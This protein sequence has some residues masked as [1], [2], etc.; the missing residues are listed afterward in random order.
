LSKVNECIYYPLALQEPELIEM[1]RKKTKTAVLVL[2]ISYLACL[3]LFVSLY[4]YNSEYCYFSLF[5][6]LI[7]YFWIITFGSKHVNNQYGIRNISGQTIIYKKKKSSYTTYFVIIVVIFLISA[8]IRLVYEV[9]NYILI[10]KVI[11]SQIDYS[12]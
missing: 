12:K 10:N 3:I 9:R 7:G 11:S 5:A 4:F 6:P 8:L 1:L 2:S